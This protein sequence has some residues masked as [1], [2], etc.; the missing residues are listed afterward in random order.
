LKQGERSVVLGRKGQGSS[1]FLNMLIGEIYIKQ[2]LIQLQGKV[3]YLS[4]EN[5]F[6][7]DTLSNNLSFYN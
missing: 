1:L 3:A 6:L 4:E 5:F 7:I 2:G